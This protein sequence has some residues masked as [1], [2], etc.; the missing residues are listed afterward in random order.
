M[1]DVTSELTLII[2]EVNPKHISSTVKRNAKLYQ[3]IANCTG[4][5]ISEKIYNYLNPDK[6]V[7][8]YVHDKKFKSIVDGYQ[9]CGPAARC[10][11]TREIV[12]LKVS[13]AKQS[14]SDETNIKINKKRDATTLAKYNVV[15]NGQTKTALI[16]HAAFYTD[17]SKVDESVEKSKATRLIKYG[18]AHYNNIEQIKETLGKRFTT[19]YAVE[20]YDNENFRILHDKEQLSA[21]YETHSAY[22]L[23]TELSVH[24]QT[25]F[26]YLN[27]YKLREPYRSQ[28]E[29]EIETFIR[30][31]GITNIVSNTRT[32][33]S[34]GKELD[35]YLPDFNIAIEYNGVYWH[36]EDVDHIHKYYHYD[37]YH[38]CVKLGIQLISIYST[39]WMYKKEIVKRSL[40]AKLKLNSSYIHA[41]KC[42]IKSVTGSDAR[43]F[44]DAYHIQGNTTSSY[45]YGLYYDDI[46]VSLMT[47]SKKRTGIGKQSKQL[48]V[49][50]HEYELVRF[51]S[52][53]QVVGGASRLLNHFIKHH[54]P[55]TIFSYS[56]NEWSDGNL[57][58]VL[59]FE[60]ASDGKPSYWYYRPGDKKMY[61]RFNFSKQKLR[62]QGFDDALT[63]NVITKQHLGLLKIWDC[64]K[65]T[66]VLNL[67]K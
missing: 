23:A 47:F 3:A 13:I 32:V 12:S 44:L 8:Q 50:E 11:C 39:S 67:T 7:C 57:Y 28:A 36:H 2:A 5:S 66:W 63:E 27:M 48:P 64:G 53:E 38:E 43:V 24:I 15:N 55:L 9:N 10:Q 54:A 40:M 30:S 17:Q 46:L 62:A 14:Y 31:V 56:D 34:S 33:L 16:A 60:L 20:R 35:L 19:E 25:V 52:S 37:K 6:N 18:N 1:T 59:G 42:N 26:R 22:E 45:K 4:N 61:H 58:A 65:K 21:L 41:R 29:R 51:A 49:N